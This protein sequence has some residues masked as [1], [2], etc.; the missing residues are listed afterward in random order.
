MSR[1]VVP[2]CSSIVVD[3][4]GIVVNSLSI[5]PNCSGIIF[6]GRG[7]LVDDL[8]VIVKGRGIIVESSVHL[9]DV[10]YCVLSTVNG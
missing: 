3:S 1:S 9:N 10:K 4:P 6:D 7:I 5:F 2:N 8:E